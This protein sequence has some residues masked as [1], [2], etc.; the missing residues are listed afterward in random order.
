M[1]FCLEPPIIVISPRDLNITEGDAATM[2]CQAD[3]SPTPVLQWIF[4][5]APLSSSSAIF[6]QGK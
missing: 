1:M 6:V 3:G 5:G 4:N 2:N